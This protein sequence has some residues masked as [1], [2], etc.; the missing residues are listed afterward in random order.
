MIEA[1]EFKTKIKNGKIEIP[2]KYRNKIKNTVKVIVMTE[3]LEKSHDII[4]E[5]LSNPIKMDHFSP[6]TREEIYERN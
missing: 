6:L 1:I 5:L 2:K 4:D 3:S